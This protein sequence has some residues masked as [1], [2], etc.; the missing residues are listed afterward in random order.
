MKAF[1]RVS[2]VQEILNLGRTKT[3]DLIRA[4]VIPSVEID[5][6]I[7]VPVKPF[8]EWQESL[9]G[10]S[11]GRCSAKVD[12]SAPAAGVVTM[13]SQSRSERKRR[14]EL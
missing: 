11:P 4:G 3:Y 1:Y 7:R 13:S 10:T 2:E 8:N 5:G 12:S 14:P 6:N 9:V